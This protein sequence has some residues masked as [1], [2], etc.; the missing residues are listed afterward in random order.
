VT[1][2]H[3][4]WLDADGDLT[5]RHLDVDLPIF[6]ERL[7]L[8]QVDEVVPAGRRRRVRAALHHAWLQVR[9]DPGSARPVRPHD[10]TGVVVHSTCA[11]SAGS[12]AATTA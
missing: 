8:G 12:P 2:T 11:G 1:L 10:I 6:P 7:P 5:T 9:P 3:G 4:E